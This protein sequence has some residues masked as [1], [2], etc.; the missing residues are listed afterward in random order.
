MD[1]HTSFLRQ[2]AQY[3]QYQ[4]QLQDYCFV[5]PN[6]RSC[7]FLSREFDITGKGVFLMP[8]IITITDFVTRLS[9]QCLVPQ[10]E[11]LF[12]LYKCYTS[13]AGNAD[14]PFDKFVYWGN[15]L[16]NDFNDVDMYLV[17]PK[18]IFTN[19]REWREI[20]S[21]YIDKDL[22][23]IVSHYFNMSN[24]GLASQDEDFW[25]NYVPSETLDEGLGENP[26]EVKAEYMRLWR[27]MLQLYDSYHAQL[28]DQGLSSKG[29]IYRNA[30]EK[31]KDGKDLGHKKYVFVGFNIIS[32]SEMAI[33]KR[34]ASRGKAL[35]FWDTSSP[36][37]D[38][39]FKNNGVK[40]VKFFEHEFPEPD[41]FIK[42]EITEFPAVEVVGVPSNVGQ[43]KYAFEI[44]KTLIAERKISNPLNAI[45]TAVVL[46]DEG[47]FLPLLNTIDEEIS[48]INVTMGYPLQGSDIASLMRVVATMHRR[49][50]RDNEQQWSFYRED[51][52]VVL[53]HPII[54][55]CYGNEALEVIKQ[56]DDDNTFAVS[57]KVF[58]GRS[59]EML[60][61]TLDDVQDSTSVTSYLEN[62]V[63]FCN[64]VL[65][66]IG[67]QAS[68]ENLQYTDEEEEKIDSPRTTTT[69]QEAFV[70]QYIDV[71]NSLID[72]LRRYPLPYCESTLFFLI[73]RL[74]SV[75]TLPLEGEPLIG[76]QVMGMLETRCLDFDNVIIL[77]ANERVLPRKFRSSTFISDYMRRCYCM[78]TTADQEAMWAYYFY[79]LISRA[80]RVYMLYDSSAQALG[81]SEVSRYVPQLEMVLGCPIKHV[82]LN[83]KVPPSKALEIKF[84]KQ[85]HVAQLLESYKAKGN[86]RLSASAINEYVNCQ[87]MFALHHI[88]HLSNDNDDADFMDYA[89]FGTIVHNTLQQL[90]YPDVNGLERTGDYKVTCAMIKEFKSKQLDTVIKRKINE[91]YVRCVNLDAPLTGEASIVSE[92][93]RMYVTAVLNHDVNLLGNIDYNYFTV[94]ECERKHDD[95]VLDYGGTKFN[96]TY[97]AD[98]IDR[99]PDGTLRIV[100][101]KTGSDH[102]SFATM[103]DLFAIEKDRRKAILQILL[104]CNAYAVANS[105]DEPIMPVIYTIKDMKEA[106]VFIKEPKK[107]KVQLN[108]YHEVNEQFKEQMDN[109]MQQMF[110]TEVPFEQTKNVGEYTSSCRYCKFVDF[111]RR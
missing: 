77:S 60:F 16:L 73:D 39:R 64:Q 68:D 91:H 36:A 105:C 11:S 78:S 109:L 13:L 63:S 61:R 25:K 72:S 88:E 110:D 9:G 51:V 92:A 76:L 82:A 17:D 93:V 83:L 19:V 46:P 8:D 20:Q 95:V 40:F 55:S 41:D 96:F 87:L 80:Q 3:F 69:V 79:R 1:H 31:V 21:T 67:N 52:K 33:F 14:Y 57:Q 27:S 53:S 15:V 7:S 56:I 106:G 62:L 35:F 107:D 6:H 48:N 43:A 30:V 101:Y 32:T 12:M 84:P 38:D 42:Q 71:L 94:L 24:E 59:F 108:D 90:Y 54:K 45:N 28:V 49:A 4:G 99:L 103:K 18:S 102:T 98:R 50:R 86:R 47:L 58:T 5:L 75:M 2:V 22:Q 34:L 104:Y 100:D 26:D 37:F 97:T 74:A 89:E 81:S 23:E 70:N 66:T 111:C 29:G 44:I 10:V 85:G 65:Q